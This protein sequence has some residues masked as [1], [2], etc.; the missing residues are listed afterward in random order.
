M[1]T[2][3]APLTALAAV[4]LACSPPARAWWDGGHMATAMVAQ[5]YIRRE[6]PEVE[7]AVG[8]ALDLFP[9]ALVGTRVPDLV[10]TA[11]WPDD[12]KEVGLGALDA[13]HFVNWVYNPE[14]I[15]IESSCLLHGPDGDETPQLPGTRTGTT[16][17]VIWTSANLASALDFC[18]GREQCD[19]QPF[20]AGFAL[21]YLTHLIGD[22][23]QPLHCVERYGEKYPHGDA[24]GNFVSV[25]VNGTS[26]KLHAYWDSCALL[27]PDGRSA[28]K[29]PLSN[30]AWAL[31]DNFAEEAMRRAGPPPPVPSDDAKLEDVLQGFAME[32]YEIA[33]EFAYWLQNGTKPIEEGDALDEEYQ[34]QAAEVVYKRIAYGGYRL[35]HV[36]RHFT[37]LPTPYGAGAVPPP[38]SPPPPPP[39]PADAPASPPPPCTAPSAA[40]PAE[41]PHSSASLLVAFVTGAVTGAMTLVGIAVAM[42]SGA[43]CRLPAFLRRGGGFD[44]DIDMGT[45]EPLVDAYA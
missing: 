23:H 25:T 42:R 33:T 34:A 12:L 8:R 9:P 19:G 22:M 38:A 36:L 32:S 35:A 26:M 15:T 45:Y 40:A 5:K 43:S 41:A 44:G 6:L 37:R 24:G 18:N 20:A 17:N 4:L 16:T 13:W 29:R 39:P 31:I 14:N 3:L 21:R 30:E 11:P 27:L 1:G 10:Q 2:A 28:L 7:E